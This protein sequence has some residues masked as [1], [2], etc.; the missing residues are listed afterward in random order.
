[1]A[2]RTPPRRS[3]T[4]TRSPETVAQPNVVD[5]FSSRFN[6]L[7]DRAGFPKSNRP[8]A[9]AKR[10]QVVLNTA[11]HWCLSDRI[12]QTH[13]DLTRI[14]EHLL[15][16]IPTRVDARAVIAWLLAGDAVPH[17]FGD[18]DTLGVVELYLEVAEFARRQGVEFSELPRDVRQVILRTVRARLGP[19]NTGDSQPR[20][21]PTT[22]E[23]L[24][25]MLE[26]GRAL[27]R[28][29]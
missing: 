9:V 1:M 20:L 10:F 24:A 17:P 3:S 7:L 23:V 11:K 12:P 25:G 2:L 28:S 4:T 21:D 19:S 26:T 14:V 8:S 15:R 29:P 16:D 5:G 13:A 27:N 6:V 22:R 18:D